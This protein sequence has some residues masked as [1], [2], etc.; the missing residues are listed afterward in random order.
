MRESREWLAER[1]ARV[2]V[3]S[4]SVCC[5]VERVERERVERVSVGLWLRAGVRAWVQRYLAHKKP[6]TP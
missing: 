5:A 4:V 2:R 6:P 1:V 3:E